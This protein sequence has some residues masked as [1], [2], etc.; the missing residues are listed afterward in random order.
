MAEIITFKHSVLGNKKVL[1]NNIRYAWK[2]FNS[3][4]SVEGKGLLNDNGISSVSQKGWSN[5]T[6]SMNIVLP[7]KSSAWYTTNGMMSWADFNAYVRDVK[8]SAATGLILSIIS[9]AD[10]SRTLTSYASSSSG[11]TDIPVVVDSYTVSID[12]KSNLYTVNIN[13]IEDV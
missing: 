13:F 7:D 5:P 2:N 3:V 6:I 8:T 10:N 9:E 1:A 11:V 12:P 4:A